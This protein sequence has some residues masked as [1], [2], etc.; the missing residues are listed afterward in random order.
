MPS[1]TFTPADFPARSRMIV[2]TGGDSLAEVIVLEWSPSA[3]YV[4]LHVE[5]P[6][7]PVAR[8]WRE[9]ETDWQ[10]VERLKG[11]FGS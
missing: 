8:F 5:P 1:L 2:N 3:K 4:R 9:P 6:G 7:E 11:S 10:L